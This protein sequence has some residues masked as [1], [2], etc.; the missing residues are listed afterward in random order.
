MSRYF[1]ATNASRGYATEGR[2]FVFEPVSL[3]GGS[4]LGVLALEDDSEASI[5]LSGGFEQ[6][7]EVNLARYEDLKKKQAGLPT[8]SPVSPLPLPGVAGV[9]GQS[10]VPGAKAVDLSTDPN[11]TAGI[12]SVTLLGRDV[13]P[14]HE[15]LLEQNPNPR[16]RRPAKAR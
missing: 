9:V 14:P 3:R 1:I 11:S 2:T 13:T 5:L 4:W 10:S 16:S 7:A 8:N 6:V 15:P 12:T